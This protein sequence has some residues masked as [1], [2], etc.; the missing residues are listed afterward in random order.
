VI[1]HVHWPLLA[2]SFLVGMVFT[3]ALLIRPTKRRAP[4][5]RSPGRS[6]PTQRKPRKQRKPV[7]KEHP[8]TKIPRAKELPTTKIPVAR[9]PP[10]KTPVTEKTSKI[11]VT[12]KTTKI[13]VTEATTKIPVTEATTKIPVTE[14]TTKIPV[15]ATRRIKMVPYAPYGQ[16]SARADPDGNGPSGWIVKGR[17]D[18]RL[19]YTEDDPTYDDTVAQIWFKDEESAARALFTPWRNRSRK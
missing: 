19:Y 7:R 13:P 17:S 8:T 3:S 5:R 6:H 2:L 12:E 10:K 16:G 18:T 11:P 15:D 9:K 14:A 4:V 1:D